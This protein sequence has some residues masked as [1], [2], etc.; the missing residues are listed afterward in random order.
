MQGVEIVQGAITSI[1]VASGA[2][3]AQHPGDW[4]VTR[5][6]HIPP[7]TGPLRVTGVGRGDTLAIELLDVAA[8]SATA[9]DRTVITLAMSGGRHGSPT[10][11]QVSV[12]C[13]GL[14]HMPAL[15]AG[16]FLSIGPVMTR[17]GQGEAGR[18]EPIAARVTVRC[19][20][21]QP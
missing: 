3:C 9:D 13:G 2:P 12:P 4:F 16:G 17:Q 21:A 7:V 6:P 10:S 15:A 5:V 8:E 14:V 19:T 11:L 18:W 1:E 20:V